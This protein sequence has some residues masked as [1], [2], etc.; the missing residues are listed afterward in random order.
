VSFEGITGNITCED[1]GDCADP[2]I[3]ISQVQDGD[4]VRI[5][6]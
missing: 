6:P 4:F 1:N 3:S 2:A 5:W